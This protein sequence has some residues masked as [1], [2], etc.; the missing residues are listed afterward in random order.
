VAAVIAMAAVLILL[1]T[2]FLV[3]YR[4]SR[5]PEWGDS[6]ARKSFLSLMVVLGP[7]FG[8]HYRE[9]RADLPAVT[10]VEPLKEPLLTTG[11]DDAH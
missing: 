10:S 3:F 7:I 2:A 8:M 1:V 11:D 6:D 4:H 9:P 5:T